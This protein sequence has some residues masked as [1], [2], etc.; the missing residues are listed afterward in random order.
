MRR[1]IFLLVFLI[2]PVFATAQTY[3]DYT[4]LTVNDSAGLLT[5]ADRAAI[6]KQL[7]SLRHDTGVEMVLLT[8][9]RLSDYA[10]N[11]SME[12]FATGLFNTWGIGDKDRN[13]GILV[14]VLA[15][16]REMRVELGSGYGRGWDNTAQWVID[17]SFLPSFRNDN[18]PK[19]IK[20]GITDIVDTI[21]RPFAANATP[22][23][24]PKAG[25]IREIWLFLAIIPLILLA[26][27]RK[28][29]DF[30]T[31]FK[32]CPSCGRKGGLRA[33]SEVTRQ[34]SKSATGLGL[35]RL[36]CSYCDLD[37]STQYTI[38]K[39]SSGS[40]SS[41]SGGSSSGGGASGKW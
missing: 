7:D 12:T 1:L 9:P 28:M 19:G 4:S 37:E 31:R 38:S 26:F 32:S 34:A 13:D 8:L 23:E 2:L 17:R 6:S 39:Q 14:L 20:T 11:T 15:E 25:G 3:P 40:S 21:A 27:R 36:T 10:A 22:P 16:D 18:Y 29:T 5:D 33:H 30:F 24:K 41:F 35:R